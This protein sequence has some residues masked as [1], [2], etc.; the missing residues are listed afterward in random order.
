MIIDDEQD[1]RAEVMAS[2]NHVAE[3]SASRTGAS[4]GQ[5]AEQFLLRVGGTSRK[6]SGPSRQLGR[7][8]LLGSMNNPDRR[9]ARHSYE[10]WFSS[11]TGLVRH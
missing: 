7:Q 6:D 9:K 3:S 2:D 8:S 4:Q 11:V 1:A 5:R 10:T